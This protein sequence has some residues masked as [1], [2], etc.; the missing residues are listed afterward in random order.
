MFR[1]VA[2]RW[3]GPTRTP[4]EVRQ[5]LWEWYGYLIECTSGHWAG[6]YAARA[7]GNPDKE[8]GEAPYMDCVVGGIVR[9]EADARAAFAA[10]VSPENPNPQH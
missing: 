10:L 7:L 8:G 4:V 5:G 3:L 9:T 1:T 6:W 2:V